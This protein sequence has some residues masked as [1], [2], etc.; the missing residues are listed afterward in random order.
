MSIFFSFFEQTDRHTRRPTQ[1]HGQ[2]EN[3]TPASLSNKHTSNQ[4][5]INS[6]L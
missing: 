5:M 2:K 1:T 4:S 6:G 3:N